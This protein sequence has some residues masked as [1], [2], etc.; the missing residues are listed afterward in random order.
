MLDA[1]VVPPVEGS[2]QPVSMQN[3]SKTKRLERM[4]YLSLGA[5]DYWTLIRLVTEDAAV[6]FAHWFYQNVRGVG[7]G[8]EVAAL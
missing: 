1:G 7:D 5:G 3:V 6:L 4:G 8:V 2:S